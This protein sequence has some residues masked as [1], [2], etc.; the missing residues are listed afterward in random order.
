MVMRHKPIKLDDLA[1]KLKVSKVT[2]SKALRNHPDIS[3]AMTQ[4]VK[5][6]AD[7]IGY[8]PNSLARNLSSR[9]S[10][11][12]GLV[13][14]KIAHIF[15][16][17]V[18]ESV[19]DEAFNNNYEIILTVSQEQSERERKHILSL[20][21]MRVDGIIISVTEQTKDINIFKKVKDFGVP[22]LF[23]DRV[24]SI[25]NVS[26]ITCDDKGGAF[27]AIEYAINK[28]YKKIAHLGGYHYINI[29][30]SR[31][32]GF[33]EAMNKYKLPISKNWVIEGGFGEEDGYNGF[34]KIFKRGD[35]PQ[36]VL[37]VTYP[38]ALGMR[39][40][41]AELGIKIPGDIEVTCFGKSTFIKQL[42]SFFNFVD[43]PTKEMGK[44]AVQTMLQMID[45]PKEFR[46]KNVKLKT[47]LVITSGVK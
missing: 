10:N 47:E 25:P 38:V 8:M 37:A 12:I 2:I 15:F 28:G 34:M 19:Y 23:I 6:L 3:P 26:S 4:K 7:K 24:P 17:S 36:Y 42:P 43:Q 22:I 46:T 5:D 44:E 45:N 20:M 1:K 32:E 14:P 40:A 29:G 27:E 9:K 30:K 11:T 39:N 41:A 21:A 18:I 31:Y 13:V 16:A 33:K 35:L